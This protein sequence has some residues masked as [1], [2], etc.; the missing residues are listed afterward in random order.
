[1]R[2]P[3]GGILMTSL[4]PPTVLGERIKGD[5]RPQPDAGD[6]ARQVT[7]SLPPAL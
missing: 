6:L 4:C 2:D 3:L 1:L 7:R 5:V